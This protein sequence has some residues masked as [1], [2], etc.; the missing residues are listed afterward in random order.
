MRLGLVV[1]PGRHRASEMA[2]RIVEL[3]GRAGIEVIG[4]QGDA[5]RFGLE[6]LDV[7]GGEVD[8]LMAVGG[9][10]TVLEGAALALRMDA[11]VLGV[12]VGRIGFLAEVEPA[13]LEAAM[14]AIAGREWSEETRGTVAARMGD[15]EPVLGVND[16]VVDK[17][18][19][20]RMVS[21]QVEIDGSV[22]TTYHA[23]GVIV[24]TATGSTAYNFSA[25]GPLVDPAVP[26][27]VL[28]A[29]APHSLLARSLVVPE[30]TVFRLQVV[31][32]RP[33]SL[34]VDGRPVGD[35]EPGTSVT[36]TGGDRRL[37][38]AALDHPAFPHL[39]VE[40]LGGRNA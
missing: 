11:P 19:S 12:N 22:Y 6:V 7:A 36:I 16:A 10:G 40:K 1:H 35:L 13:A 17:A 32:E 15:G 26:A 21:L 25:G 31:D 27:L 4:R 38:L 14:E 20:S 28:S 18:A 29:V 8:L 39:V 23:D 33:A 2:E 34:A 37:R 24:A 5:E 3:A 9:D 30:R